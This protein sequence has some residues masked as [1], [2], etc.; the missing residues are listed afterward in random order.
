MGH[1]GNGRG[2]RGAV[3]LVH[4]SAPAIRVMIVDDVPVFR[5]GLHKLL[6]ERGIDVVG[7]VGSGS[8]VVAQ[9]VRLGPDV[10]VLDLDLPGISSVELM[11]KLAAAAP[12]SRPVVLTVSAEDSQVAEAIHAGACGYILKDAPAEEILACIRAAAAGG[13]LVS[14]G[15]AAKLLSWFRQSPTDS[16]AGHTELSPR[17]LEVLRLIADGRDN[18][19]I[20]EKLFLSNS[21]VKNHVSRI[22]EKLNAK[23]RVQAA[24][25]AVRRGII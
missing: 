3:D 11:R 15:I 9:A 12:R 17:E 6:A 24:V 14:P 20:A 8:D 16:S 22:L 25:Y 7:E 21:T 5:H 10:I 2:A 23:N 4:V 13:F 1:D 18:G 19:E